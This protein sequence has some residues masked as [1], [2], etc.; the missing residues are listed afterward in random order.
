MVNIGW[1]V[2][3]VDGSTVGCGDKLMMYG[4]GVYGAWASWS[5][6]EEM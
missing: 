3:F 5:E 2:G 4:V 1:Q 6:R